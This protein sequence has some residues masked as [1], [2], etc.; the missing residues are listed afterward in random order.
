MTAESLLQQAY[1]PESFRRAG[2]QLIDRL[3]DHL[4][5]MLAAEGPV[6]HQIPPDTLYDA[7]TEAE[8]GPAQDPSQ[9][10]EQVLGQAIYLH[11][12]HYVGH[13]ISPP[14]P[15]AA[16]AGLLGDFLNNGMGVYEMGA[17]G[18]A[19]ERRV[20]ALVATAMGLGP[21]ADGFMTS[22]GTLGNLT[23]LLAARQQRS[24]HDVWTQGHQNGYQPA[25]MVSAQAHYC[26]KRAA[27]VMGWG[28]AGVIQVP[29]DENFRIRTDLLPSLLAAA[30]ARGLQVIAAVG[31]ACTTATGSFDDLEAMADFCE[32]HGLWF[33]VD[34][35]HGGPTAFSETW[36]H[37]L[38]GISRADTVVIDFHKMALT[39]ALAT[40]VIFRDGSLSYCTFEQ[41]AH[42]LWSR[43]QPEWY[44]LAKRTFECTKYMMS[45]KA[46]TALQAGGGRVT[47]AFVDTMYQLGQTFAEMIL[48]RSDMELAVKPM[49]NIVCFRWRPSDLSPDQVSPVNAAIRADIIQS[50]AFYLVQTTLRGDTWLRVSLMNPFTRASHL[51]VLLDL[52]AATG[53][54]LT[55]QDTLTLV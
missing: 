50:G 32:A 43:Q 33:H 28:E 11:H 12:P 52:V 41:D 16:L 9:F 35:A 3:A 37:L 22:G 29:V 46:Y 6:H 39:P 15:T 36:R 20:I 45:L 13:Q 51:Q 10:F 26:V 48:A 8:A 53:I 40:G 34:A 7:W 49:C 54:R 47:G 14:L 5:H 18:T 31:S 4:Q 30:Q 27:Q 24:G 21:Q 2:H 55:A 25:I 42:Y 23:A 1:D 19:L 38:Q 44:N 17:S